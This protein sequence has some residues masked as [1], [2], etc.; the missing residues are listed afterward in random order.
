MLLFRGWSTLADLGF[1]GWS[2]KPL[3]LGSA[4]FFNRSLDDSAFPLFSFFISVNDEVDLL[5]AFV[6]PISLLAF[7]VFGG[8]GSV[9][10]VV[11][12]GNFLR[13]EEDAGSA[14]L[15]FE[16]LQVLGETLEEGF[17][18]GCCSVVDA[19]EVLLLAAI[20]FCL[21]SLSLSSR[22]IC[23]SSWKCKKLPIRC[24]K[25]LEI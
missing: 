7:A 22:F 5:T 1:E 19:L 25:V 14:S 4:S 18:L 15:N 13:G 8:W 2:V 12:A 11:L 23:S 17:T 20:L 16:L 3:V 21:S 24:C 10:V 6:L 9:P